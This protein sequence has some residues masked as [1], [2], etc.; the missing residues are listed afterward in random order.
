[1][2]GPRGQEIPGAAGVARKT[3]IVCTLGPASNSE[4]VL[5][6][7][8]RMGMD[9]ARLNF[10]HGTHEEHARTIERVRKVAEKRAAPSA[11]CRTCKGPRSAPED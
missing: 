10:S 6:D 7:M 2:T 1:M 9:V 8:M 3:K 4:P 11:F 5:R